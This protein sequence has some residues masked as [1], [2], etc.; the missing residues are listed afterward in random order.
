MLAEYASVVAPENPD[1]KPFDSHLWWLLAG[2]VFYKRP[3]SN[4]DI[5]E[6]VSYFASAIERNKVAEDVENFRE[7]IIVCYEMPG[8]HSQQNIWTIQKFHVL[9][10]CC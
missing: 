7:R 8:Y 5:K 3:Q 4:V 6:A 9:S 1:F 10:N 2:K